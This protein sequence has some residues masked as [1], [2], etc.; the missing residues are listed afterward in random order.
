MVVLWY[1]CLVVCLFLYL[2]KYFFF[3][4]GWDDGMVAYEGRIVFVFH[5]SGW[6]DTMFS[7]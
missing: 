2:N 3:S 1:V 5:A 7:Y 6:E 4:S